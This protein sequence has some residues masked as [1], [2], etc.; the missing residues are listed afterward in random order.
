MK[1]NHR[2]IILGLSVM[3]SL[4]IASQSM[5]G[6]VGPE[7]YDIEDIDGPIICDDGDI[8]MGRISSEEAMDLSK[9]VG[10]GDISTSGVEF[11]DRS[12][13][14]CQYGGVDLE[15][16]DPIRSI[17]DVES[18]TRGSDDELSTSYMDYA[19][20]SLL[21]P[22]GEVV[23]GTLDLKAVAANSDAVDW[24]K[25]E[26]TDVDP[27]PNSANGV[28]NVSF[29]LSTYAR[30]GGSI[31]DLYEY[32]LADDGAGG[33]DLAEDY[34]DYLG[35]SILYIDEWGGESYMGGNDLFFDDGDDDDGWV[36]DGKN[37]Q[38]PGDNW[39]VNFVTPDSSRLVGGAEV[40]F[41]YIG[42]SWGYYLSSTA[43]VT[44]SPFEIDYTFTVDTSVKQDNDGHSN[45]MTNAQLET[46]PIIGRVDSMYDQ[47]D[48]MKVQG[49]DPDLL[50]NMTI[51]VRRDRTF[52]GPDRGTW[53]GDNWMNIFVV[54]RHSGEDGIFD[55]P[56]D[57][58]V[59]AHRILSAYLAGGIF[60]GG[61]FQT[62]EGILENKWTDAV[63]S[64]R[65]VYIGILGE[66]VDIEV[67]D[68]EWTGVYSRYN[69]W[70]S[71]SEYT[72]EVSII[73]ELP[74]DPPRIGE[75][76][77][78]SDY[79]Q[80]EA[81]GHLG[82]IFQINVTYSDENNDPPGG[83][84]LRMDSLISLD[85]LNITSTDHQV[86]MLDENYQ[87]GKAYSVTL[88]G[89]VIGDDPAVHDI[90]IYAIDSVQETSIRTPE[91]SSH[92]YLNG[93]LEVWDDLPLS[94]V[95]YQVIPSM[96][97]DSNPIEV[98]LM[99][100]AGEGL[101]NDPENDIS[102][103]LVWNNSQEAWDDTSDTDLLHL[104]IRDGD[105][106]SYV[107]ISPKGGRHGEEQIGIKAYDE[108]SWADGN[109]TVT[110]TPVNDMP[111][112]DHI[113]FQ[114]DEFEVD[115]QGTYGVLCDLSGLDIK[116]DMDYLFQI[117]AHDTD[118]EPDISELEYLVQV[119]ANGHWENEIGINSA[120]GDVII[121]PTNR[122]AGGAQPMSIYLIVQEEGGEHVID[123][124]VLVSVS[125]VNDPPEM[126]PLELTGA[127]KQYEQIRVVPTV[128]DIDKGEVLFY[129]V[130]V[131]VQIEDIEPLSEQL[132]YASLIEGVDWTL[133]SVS[134]EFTLKLDDQNIWKTETGWTDQVEVTIRIQ[135]ADGGDGSDHRDLKLTLVN[136]NDGPP[137]PGPINYV[138]LDTEE[139]AREKQ[140]IEY[141]FHI[142]PLVDPDGDLLT[143]TWD[144]GDGAKGDG[145][146]VNH[147]YTD[148]GTYQ[149]SLSASDGDPQLDTG[150]FITLNVV[151]PPVI[152]DP[153]DP[154]GIPIAYIMGAIIA[155][156]LIISIIIGFMIIRRK[157]PEA[158]DGPVAAG[159]NIGGAPQWDQLPMPG[160]A[161]LGSASSENIHPPPITAHNV[162]DGSGPAC[163]H[164][165]AHVEEGWFLCPNCKSPL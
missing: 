104:E 56:D 154:E 82:S 126:S 150:G 143:Y 135:V 118:I 70:R 146:N 89:E 27:G 24:Y 65:Q 160:P 159:Q 22:S 3:I 145:L 92:H 17:F 46:S 103:Y 83:I 125:N 42:I 124:E 53:L 59:H 139:E 165:G 138:I 9:I 84:Y 38:Y 44:R 121:S 101:F 91:W 109:Y 7:G 21:S 120:T 158:E 131:E 152:P 112:V 97:E 54:W 55:T 136:V 80:S 31:D 63:P 123:L 151:I 2:K 96:A 134:G 19:N 69:T 15:R 34:A 102:G 43:P 157:G 29:T 36:W 132:P 1:E 48:W 98:Q 100:L 79:E 39:T 71:I 50:W 25:L 110:V 11:N 33:L 40:D 141:N 85:I 5:D 14:L 57:E 117:L 133:N 6:T 155:V 122:D 30:S 115:D 61:E 13:H 60:V 49:S 93:T 99:E 108:H 41:Y 87:D 144:F 52:I 119:G 16:M 161:H 45:D 147:T 12:E 28:Y 106:N 47:V 90:L 164:C 113:L 140:T 66:A 10:G 111:V 20:G 51:T 114:G 129:S 81:G 4:I 142:S 64:D 77:V 153:P 74:N 156:V 162:P 137:D 26:L 95:Q 58:W 23:S 18:A 86:D 67:Q 107:V 116:E 163:D 94:R 37:D 76:T 72:I 105:W 78:S 75:I 148:G 32:S 62:F 127:P 35:I 149:V 130:N 8:S 73:E 68:D 128:I 88:T